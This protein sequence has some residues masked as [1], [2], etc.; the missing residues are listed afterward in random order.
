MAGLPPWLAKKPGNAAEDRKDGG[1]DDA[2][3]RVVPK[4]K[5]GKKN[6]PPGL[7]KAIA[8]KI[9]AK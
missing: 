5:G 9:G 8:R 7:Q 1:L 2:Q 3:E 4:K 6:V